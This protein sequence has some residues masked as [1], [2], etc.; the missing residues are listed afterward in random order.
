ML[1]QNNASAHSAIRVRQFLAQKMV[2]MLN[3]PPYSLIWLL[4]TSSYFLACRRPSK[5]H[6]LRT[7]M[8]WRHRVTA[9]LRSIPH[10]AFAHCFRKLF[11]SLRESVWIIHKHIFCLRLPSLRPV[12]HFSEK[13]GMWNVFLVM[14]KEDRPHT[15]RR[16]DDLEMSFPT[17]IP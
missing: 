6:V 5:V 1:I 17:Q 16:N 15:M 10:Q 11:P 7:W 9:V 13:C 4:R 12:T 3:H 14:W 8:P 2:A